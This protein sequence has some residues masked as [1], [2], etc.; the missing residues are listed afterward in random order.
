MGIRDLGQICGR[1][2]KIMSLLSD[3]K[4]QE[5][6]LRI[7]RNQYRNN[8]VPH[9][10]IFCGPKGIG[11]QTT[12]SAFSKLLNCQFPL[13]EIDSC[14]SCRSCRMVESGNHSEIIK[15]DLKWQSQILGKKEK[16]ASVYYKIDTIHELIKRLNLKADSASTRVVIIDEAELLT[17]DASGALLKTLE[18]PPGRTVFILVV[19]NLER[20]LPTIISRSQLVRFRP[21]A[22]EV[23]EKV[24]CGYHEGVG[25]GDFYAFN[26][27]PGLFVDSIDNE[28][29]DIGD[30]VIS[31]Y[32]TK[33]SKFKE[34]IEWLEVYGN[35]RDVLNE[36]LNR[37]MRRLRE[38]QILNN[39]QMKAVEYILQ[40]KRAQ[41][42]FV[43]NQLISINL[44]IKMK[45]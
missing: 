16:K 41:E 11:K 7:L 33:T 42:R 14:G 20:I 22:R 45:E 44:L 10:Y 43:S 30:E 28:E 9:C 6:V 36:L 13:D 37:L 35:D 26:A 23:F 25:E 32:L 2:A 31:N 1:S 27:S 40:A 24:V 4:G 34:M 8:R 18:E 3:I 19:E 17:E 38:N 29:E 39:D 5:N 15:V 12:A 21:L